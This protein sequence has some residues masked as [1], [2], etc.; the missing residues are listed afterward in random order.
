MLCP[1]WIAVKQIAG[2]A[3][4]AR[5]SIDIPQPWSRA[6]SPQ[7]LRNHRLRPAALLLLLAASAGAIAQPP[8]T[9]DLDFGIGGRVITSLGANAERLQAVQVR[10]DE[11]IVVAGFSAS[12]P[13][14][15]S[16]LAIA[17]YLPNGLLDSAFGTN[18]V[19]RLDGNGGTVD[20]ANALALQRDGKYLIAGA[21]SAASYSDFGVVRVLDNGLV[22]ASFGSAGIARLNLAP[23]TNRND[24][25]TSIAIQGSG[26]IVLGGAAFATEGAFDYIRF[27]LVRFDQ[28]GVLDSGFGSAGTVIAPSPVI[29]GSDYLTAIARLPNGRLPSGDALTVVGHS[30][31]QNTA[32]IRRYT[33]N[34]Q[35][36]GSFGSGGQ[37]LISAGNSGGVATGLSL[38]FAAVLQLDGR[39]VVVGQGTDRGFAFMRL[40]TN[41]AIDTSFGTNGRAHVKFSGTSLYDEAF[42][43]TV[44]GNGKIVAAG[45]FDGP[46]SGDFA[47]AR[48]LP[49]GAI[50]S[51]FGDGAGRLILPVSASTLDRVQGVALAPS[52]KL[53]L[54]G[55]VQ[56]PNVGNQQEDFALAR[57]FGDPDRIFADGFEGT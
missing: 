48:L 43:V 8:G 20:F 38:I 1:A 5:T 25:A 6:M 3:V 49:N 54:A 53:V 14:S 30:A 55:Y 24:Y 10:A 17:R 29:A 52:G 42:A 57:V 23:V 40:L 46:P 13:N 56:D 22:D 35:P 21:V 26:K 37:V 47:V 19:T 51:G 33:A 34:G 28:N 45:Y 9:L 39:L 50:D 11:S 31:S 15:S 12:G 36:D 41:G 18:G 16:N 4:V 27:G 32:I 2:F 7:P 44:Q